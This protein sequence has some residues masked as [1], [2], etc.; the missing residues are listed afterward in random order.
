MSKY[1]PAQVQF[2]LTRTYRITAFPNGFTQDAI[3]QAVAQAFSYWAE[4]TPL[5]FIA[6]EAGQVD[7][8]IRFTTLDGPEGFLGN[9][10]I[11]IDDAERWRIGPSE[12]NV[13]GAS[14]DLITTI[15]HEIGHR[16]SLHHQLASVMSEHQ[17]HEAEFRNAGPVDVAAIQ[18]IFGAPA[19]HTAV[20][21]HGASAV[22][23]L[24]S[25]FEARRVWGGGS[26][27]IGRQEHTAWIHVPLVWPEHKAGPALFVHRVALRLNLGPGAQIQRMDVSASRH[28][29]TFEHT[30]GTTVTTDVL[31]AAGLAAKPRATGALNIS[32][33]VAF[34]TSQFDAR[35]ID[36]LAAHVE[37]VIDE[38]AL[39]P[40]FP[41][42][43]APINLAPRVPDPGDAP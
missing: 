21:V 34:D 16:L 41:T 4:V 35:R 1:T 24:D 9:A 26:A 10:L 37:L 19:V 43:N 33:K 30:I 36:V 32:V 22:G 6:Q 29:Q 20:H 27:F 5:R 2:S 12:E 42:E 15:T 13:G 31:L 25:D 8:E 18:A 3:R 28:L 39:T 14:Y 23:E 40:V 17:A 7:I 11:E 38:P